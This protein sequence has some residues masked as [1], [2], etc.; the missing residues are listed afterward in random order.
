MVSP[1][2]TI[3]TCD[4]HGQKVM[5]NDVLF[6]GSD[7]VVVAIDRTEGVVVAVRPN[8]RGLDPTL[9]NIGTTI[10]EAL[11]STRGE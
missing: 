6:D 11:A 4:H 5:V 9:A 10:A 2:A 3:I 8:K 7:I 1:F